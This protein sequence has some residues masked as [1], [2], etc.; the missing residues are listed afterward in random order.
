M[1]RNHET[2]ARAQAVF[3]QPQAAQLIVL[4]RIRTGEIEDTL[5][6]VGQDARQ[7]P[8]QV[9]RYVASCAPSGR[10]MSSD[11]CGFHIG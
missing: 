6:R 11:P 2:I 10:P 8:F 3:R 5:G 4:V 7:R 1:V 9:A